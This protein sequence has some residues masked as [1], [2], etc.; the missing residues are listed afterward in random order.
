[1]VRGFKDDKGRF[2]PTESTVGTSSRFHDSSKRMGLDGQGIAK[3]LL[4]QA[5]VFAKNRADQFKKKQKEIKERQL[6]ELTVRRDAEK[7]IIS[8]FKRARNLQIK[9]PVALKN[10]ILIDVP[11]IEDNKENLKFIENILN[12]FIQREKKKDKAVK[13]AKTDTEKIRIEEDFERAEGAEEKEVREEI[14]RVIARQEKKIGKKVEDENKKLKEQKKVSDKNVHELE[15]EVQGLI[16]SEDIL[17]EQEQETEKKQEET[18]KKAI[19]AEIREKVVTF[20]DEALS[21]ATDE[22]KSTAI[23]EGLKSDRFVAGEKAQDALDELI[24]AQKETL[25]EQDK[26]EQKKENAEQK[27]EDVESSIEKAILEQ[28]ETQFSVEEPTKQEDS[29]PLEII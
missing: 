6:R 3:Q 18:E 12:G 22:R 8:S 17:V 7:R 5:G 13:K 20:A 9:D 14:K 21:Q 1:M 25:K 27:R 2:H 15:K 24:K 23:K 16:K 26:E 4:K 29:F 10:Q 19:E 28:K 11:E